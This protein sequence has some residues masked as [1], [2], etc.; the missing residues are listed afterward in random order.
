MR[1]QVTKNAI[2]IVT[3]LSNRRRILLGLKWEDA[4]T[5]LRS[6]CPIGERGRYRGRVGVSCS[7]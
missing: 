5:Q 1:E 7:T 2:Y 4:S 3:K 6:D